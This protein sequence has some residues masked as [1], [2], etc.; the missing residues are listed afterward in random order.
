VRRKMPKV[1]KTY[2]KHHTKAA[3]D[4]VFPFKGAMERRGKQ[5]FQKRLF[6]P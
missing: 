1:V 3:D 4:N 5:I 6:S 2:L